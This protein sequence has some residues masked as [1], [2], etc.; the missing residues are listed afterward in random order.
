[1]SA[2]TETI[3]QQFHHELECFI[4]KKV[5]DRALAKDILQDVFVKIHLHLHTIQDQA[6]LNA[7]I[8]QLTRHTIIDYYRRNEEK[9]EIPEDITEYNIQIEHGLA[10]CVSPFISLL[11]T[12][13]QEALIL[14]D[15]NGMSQTQLAA[16]LNISYSAAK[17][18]VQRARQKLKTL[19]TDCC[20][21]HT[22]TYGNVLSYK[23][24][25]CNKPCD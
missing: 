23:K 11:P 20:S 5:N 25:D 22:D 24:L 8:Y 3:Y 7:W 21:I 15:I 19:F 10:N 6:K 9:I 18:R 13:Y 4:V 16:Q 1:M 14:T 17:S 12:K 2:I